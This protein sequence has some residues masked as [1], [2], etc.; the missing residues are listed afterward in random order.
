MGPR[1]AAAALLVLATALLVPAAGAAASG[2]GLRLETLEG[3]AVE[4]ALQADESALVVH[5]WATWCPECVTELPL[6]AEA[7]ARCAGSG[8]RIATVDVGESRE[9]IAAYLEQHAL[10]LTT[11][12][13]PRGRTW[14][15]LG[16]RGLPTNLTWTRS[17]RRLDVG[18]RDAETWS[19]TLRAL[20]CAAMRDDAPGARQAASP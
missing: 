17:G 8:V 19:Q 13:D 16:G 9:T 1:S 6:L 7:A 2:E 18:S 5:F 3:E 11:F 12:R 4:L 20:G 14:R 10:R 15:S